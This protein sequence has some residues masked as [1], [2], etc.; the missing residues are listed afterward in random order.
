MTYFI[1]NPQT[2]SLDDSDHPT[3]IR[4]NLG[5]KLLAK[6]DDNIYPWGYDKNPPWAY[7]PKDPFDPSIHERFL[8]DF[9]IRNETMH[10]DGGRVG[11]ANGTKAPAAIKID[12]ANPGFTRDQL[13]KLY[14]AAGLTIEGKILKR[15]RPFMSPHGKN[16]GLSQEMI[17]K[18]KVVL[19]D[20]INYPTKEK[21]MKAL[22][23]RTDP[24]P[25]RTFGMGSFDRLLDEYEKATGTKINRVERFPTSFRYKGSE[26]SKQIGDAAEAMLVQGN[27]VNVKQLARVHLK[28]RFLKDP[29]GARQEIRR[30]LAT[31]GIDID[32][33][34]RT[35]IK[36]DREY[37]SNKR[38]DNKIK[39]AAKMAG[40]EYAVIA[41]SLIEDVRDLNNYY[42]EL[43]KTNPDAI[44]K[45]KKLVDA[46]TVQFDIDTGKVVRPKVSNEEILRRVSKGIFELEHIR[47]VSDMEFGTS[48]AG[49]QYVTKG[50]NI[51]YPNNLQITTRN[52]N[53]QFFN[54][55]RL[56][57]ARNN[58]DKMPVDAETV[59][60]NQNLRTNINGIMHGAQSNNVG[61][62]SKTKTSP[63]FKNNLNA[64]DLDPNPK[65]F[66]DKF[67][68][69]AGNVIKPVAK[70]AGKVALKV[71]GTV[72]PPLSTAS[73][74][75][76]LYDMNRARAEGLNR[77]Q[78]LGTAYYLGPEAAQGM[79]N[80]TDYDYKDRV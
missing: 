38:R 30:I 16:T 76:G 74:G 40:K 55:V 47:P 53:G 51:G 17:E 49:K 70:Y 61:W 44:L 22:G 7:I 15:K 79:R 31:E 65:L 36:G 43:A 62:D 9:D 37:I 6:K 8:E 66:G 34:G 32:E 52:M 5:E 12:Q 48:K 29:D 56:Y 23:Y 3:P 27:D 57:M 11:L 75:L 14:K 54:N 50:V 80:I 71:L 72:I 73:V 60:K 45:N 24:R 77:P 63:I 10:A 33:V 68:K 35:N 46:L 64:L 2:N 19:D 18:V 69:K 41:N 25:G 26:I 1:F 28:D 59:F 39:Y 67:L 42:K 78:E 20:P 21:M 13:R 4:K 58:L